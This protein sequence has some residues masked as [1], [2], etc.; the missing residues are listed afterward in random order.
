MQNIH[1]MQFMNFYVYTIFRLS[2]YFP[3]AVCS[4]HP[5]YYIVRC[6]FLSVW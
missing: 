5:S 2:V 6:N 1:G 3:F 4:A